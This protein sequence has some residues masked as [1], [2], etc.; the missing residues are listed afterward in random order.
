[1]NHELA[2]LQAIAGELRELRVKVVGLSVLTASYSPRERARVRAMARFRMTCTGTTPLLM[3]NSRLSNPL[4]DVAKAMKR[5]SAKRAKTEDD[6]E[7]LARLEHMGSLY[8]DPDMGPYMPGQNFERCL[9]DAARITK[10]GKKIER[11]VFVETNVNP[12]AY[13]GPRTIEGLWS[14]ANFRHTA[15]VKVQQNRVTRT[16]P[17]FRTWVTEADGIYDPAVIN[18]EELAEIADTAGRMIGLGDWRPRYGRF[19]VSVEKLAA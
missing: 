8:F 16:R 6:H 7:E 14:D 1:M 5:I 2:D 3:H 18:L 17:Q 11:G 19:T 15:S 4:D 13:D 12:V 10:A 9:V